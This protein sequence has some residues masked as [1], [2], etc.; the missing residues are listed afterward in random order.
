MRLWV[1]LCLLPLA[2]A[3]VIFARNRAPWPRAPDAADEV[4]PT[5]EVSGE[6]AETSSPSGPPVGAPR[7]AGQALRAILAATAERRDPDRRPVRIEDY[8]GRLFLSDRKRG[9]RYMALL[10]PTRTALTAAAA[11]CSRLATSPSRLLFNI[12][13]VASGQRVEIQTMGFEVE[14]GAPLTPEISRCLG[15]RV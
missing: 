8:L 7:E 12:R 15:T 5:R 3:I 1:G 10:D 2:V 4:P 6:R 9:L 14:R 11:E 13:V